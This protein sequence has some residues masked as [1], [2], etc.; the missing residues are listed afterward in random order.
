MRYSRL[1]F[2]RLAAGAAALPAFPSTLRANAYPARPVRIIVGFAAG[3]PADT[4]MRLI[5]QGLSERLGQSF[6][7]E[8]R[9]GAGGNIGVE[10]V[11]RAPADGYTLL[12][13]SSPNTINAVNREK[14]NFDLV[15]DIA[16]VAGICRVPN[17]VVVHPSV[18]VTSVPEFIA[19]CKAYP[20]KLSGA[21]GGIGTSGHVASELFKLATGVDFV[22]VPYRGGG[23]ALTD[24]I[25]GQV[26]VYFGP[27]L[28]TIEA[29]R[30]GRLRAL[31]VT[32]AARLDLLPG[33]PAIAEFVPGYEAS[34]F[35][36]IGAPRDTPALIV[37]RLNQEINAALADP[38]ITSRLSR[39]GGTS[40][41]GSPA[42]FG[43]L[44]A[45]EA[46]KWARVIKLAGIKLQ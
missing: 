18:P 37:D 43:K 5:G 39:L 12:A 11:V 3:G 10:A 27:A 24:L 46:E 8:N 32:A 41:P 44:I 31:G 1:Q 14:L 38:K 33:L 6:V 7:V 13:V 19:Y 28:L 20:G 2:L 35:F 9:P 21:V 25:A 4:L 45:A 40:L 23:P 29:I 22:L 36:G 30:T 26:Q 34:T 17:V 16:G 42:D 15:R